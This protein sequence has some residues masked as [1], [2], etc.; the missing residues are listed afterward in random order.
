[1][2][3]IEEKI[4]QQEDFTVTHLEL[5]E[6]KYCK[7]IDCDFSHTS[8]S[9]IKFINCVFIDCN[10]SNVSLHDTMFQEVLF[11][12]SKALGLRFEDCR[13]LGLKVA[14]TNCILDHCSFYSMKIKK[15]MFHR[16]SV[17]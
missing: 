7:F 14:F 12:D 5:A 1:M 17:T 6:Y 8:L 2:E 11:K 4:F 10:L 3:Y 9:Y 13:A 16:I 15:Y